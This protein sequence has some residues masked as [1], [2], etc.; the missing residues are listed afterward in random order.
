MF[1]SFWSWEKINTT[2]KPFLGIADLT[3]VYW[4]GRIHKVLP[5]LY[6]VVALCSSYLKKAYLNVNVMR[7]RLAEFM[8]AYY[9]WNSF[10]VSCS[11]SNVALIT[12]IMIQIHCPSQ[13]LPGPPSPN[14]T[15]FY[16]QEVTQN[17]PAL[18]GPLWPDHLTLWV[19]WLVPVSIH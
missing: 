7:T 8:H 2:H 1:V 10:R 13:T 9:L 12:L 6:S 5:K 18:S 17:W 15:H 3:G 16:G 4:F 19:T 11:K 14:G